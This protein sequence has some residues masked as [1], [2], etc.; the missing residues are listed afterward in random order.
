[1]VW[2]KTHNLTNEGSRSSLQQETKGMIPK[3]RLDRLVSAA[4]RTVTA[5]IKNG[6]LVR[7]PRCERCGVQSRRTL[8]AHHDDYGKPLEVRWYC[9][10]CH[11]HV[12]AGVP[13][14]MP[15][16][17]MQID[18]FTYLALERAAT[19]G[20]GP[21]YLIKEL[22]ARFLSRLKADPAIIQERCR[23]CKKRWFPRN[24]RPRI[25]PGCKSSH[26]NDLK[27]PRVKPKSC[28]TT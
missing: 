24:G 20:R 2:G 18:Q 5:A 11:R 27:A 1:M 4:H 10:T 28:S 13:L 19:K 21:A 25:C 26:W 9:C 14:F 6:T 7:P 8:H 12:H 15:P 23:L 3:N 17:S 16:V 22:V